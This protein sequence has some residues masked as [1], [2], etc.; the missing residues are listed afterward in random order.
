MG[1]DWHASEQGFV[2]KRPRWKPEVLNALADS[3]AA[4]VPDASANW[5]AKTVVPFTRNGD[6][7]AFA[8]LHTKRP[9]GLDLTIAVEPGS[10]AFGRVATLG[11]E[12]ELARH[13]GGEAVKVR[14]K[15][16]KQASDPKLK[17]LLS[18]LAGG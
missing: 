10:L 2:G 9:A 3:I 5:T 15:T 4:A 6:G 16:V 18:E 12:R 17:A 1:K 8:E 14:F 7:T 11:A 13:R